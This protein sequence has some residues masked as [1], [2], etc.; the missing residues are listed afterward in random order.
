MDGMSSN[1]FVGNGFIRSET[2]VTTHGLLD[3]KGPNFQHFP[4]QHPA[5]FQFIVKIKLI[6]TRKSCKPLKAKAYS[7]FGT[8]EGT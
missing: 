3:G 1:V 2:S 6:Y 5:K 7:F 4:I 8:S